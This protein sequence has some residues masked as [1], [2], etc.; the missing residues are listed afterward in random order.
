MDRRKILY[1]EDEESLGRIVT[2]TLRKKGY[3]TRWEKD[4]RLVLAAVDEFNPE[5]CLLDIMLPGID[6]YTLCN[7]IR[8]QYPNLPVIFLTART[9]TEDL[10]RGFEA[11]G[12]DYIKKPFA[13]EELVARIENQ[14]AI[15]GE[16]RMLS[17]PVENISLGK[18]SYLP[19]SNELEGPE[20]T[21]RLSHRE[22][23]VL[24]FLCTGLNRVTDRKSLLLAVWGDDSFF[25][26]RNL[27]VYIRKIRAYLK[28]DQRITLQ[29]LKGK[30][31]LFLVPV[32]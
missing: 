15:R 24:R 12:S 31:Y 1:I 30:G 27:D 20:G 32:D 5:L 14:F 21:L 17:L 6:G 16:D 9:E 18:Y 22:S 19:G 7:S 13:V 2:D 11:G 4:G 10:V 25:N 3:D 26:S 28:H 29:T 23:Q 8:S